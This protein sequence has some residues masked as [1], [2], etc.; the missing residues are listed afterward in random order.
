VVSF[1]RFFDQPKMQAFITFL[2]GQMKTVGINVANERP[3]CI[4]PSNPMAQNGV[5]SRRVS[6]FMS[7]WHSSDR[8]IRV[9]S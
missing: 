5:V 1:D 3:P 2:V 6:G 9:C 8:S 4:G 7:L